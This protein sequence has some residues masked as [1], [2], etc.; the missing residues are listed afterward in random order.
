[1]TIRNDRI[2]STGYGRA[3]YLHA[4]YEPSTFIVDASGARPLYDAW[5]KENARG[6]ELRRVWKSAN[7]ALYEARKRGA[8]TTELEE[9]EVKN[10]NAETAMKRHGS[11]ALRALAKFDDAV[12]EFTRSAD[13]RE[14]LVDAMLAADA[15]AKA[16]YEELIDTLDAREDLWKKAGSPAA[17]LHYSRRGIARNT[18][19]TVKAAKDTFSRML[20]QFPHREAIAASFDERDA[21]EVR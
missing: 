21:E 6:D 10:R 2:T 13:A 1:M 9:L 20:E 12:R 14:G 17:L 15:K 7:H 18:L 19:G 5:Q 8:F 3:T 4:Q 11:V 16:L